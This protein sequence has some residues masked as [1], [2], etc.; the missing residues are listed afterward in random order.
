MNVEKLPAAG[1]GST[2]SSCAIIRTHYSTLDGSALAYEG[3]FYWDDWAG[4]LGVPDERGLAKFHKTGCL[5]MK[6]AGNGYLKSVC[7]QQDALGIPWEDWGPERIGAAFRSTTSHAFGPPK[8]PDDPAFG[9][10]GESALGARVLSLRRLHRRPAACDPQRPARRRGPRRRVPLQCRGHGDPARRRPGRRRELKSGEPIDAP[11]VVNIAG[12]HS[13]KINRMAGVEDGMKIR[14]RA[15][16]Q[17]VAHVPFPAGFDFERGASSPRI[18]TSAA[19]A[20]RRS[21]T[22]S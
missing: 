15:L 7:A 6:T 16:K 5:V 22:T 4:Y 20:G 18:P 12:P 11:V 3:C 21:A 14:T 17:E 2:G 8:R 1:Y 9:E 13:Y 10:P 19:T